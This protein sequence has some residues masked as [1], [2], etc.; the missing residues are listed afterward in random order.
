MKRAAK[1][2][3]KTAAELTNKEKEQ[4]VSETTLRDLLGILQPTLI[5]ALA[6]TSQSDYV[7]SYIQKGMGNPEDY[8]YLS[9]STGSN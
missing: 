6:K 7:T 8:N 3:G 5:G 9:G 1:K 4:I 2:L